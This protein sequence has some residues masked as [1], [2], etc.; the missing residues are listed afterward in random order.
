MW[1]N[2]LYT[3]SAVVTGVARALR[4]R[5]AKVKYVEEPFLEKQEELINDPDENATEEQKK[6]GREQLLMKLQIMQ[7]NFE[8]NHDE[9]GEASE[10]D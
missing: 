5:K 1:R 7:A 10:D 3:L 8:M 4:G 6:R 2:G 9:E